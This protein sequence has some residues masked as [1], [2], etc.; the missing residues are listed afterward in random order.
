VGGHVLGHLDVLQLVL[1]DGDE[2]AVVGEDVGGHEDRVE[3]QADR[4]GDVVGELVLVAVGALEQAHAGDGGEQPG[5]LDDLGDVGLAE[6]D[7]A[8]G[9]EA[10][11]EVGEG[12]VEDVGA[13]E[14][15]VADGGEG[16]VV[17]DEVEGVSRVGVLQGDVL[18]D[19]A[20]VIAEV[21]DAGGLDAG[22][23]ARDGGH[24]GRCLSG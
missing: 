4:G 17:G 23:D 11:G 6:Q 12:G 5:E 20:E 3:E 9:V 7:G 15:R 13:Q 14:R 21:E 1:A 2:G 22:E 24:E 8:G 10:E 18:A 16:V 19:G